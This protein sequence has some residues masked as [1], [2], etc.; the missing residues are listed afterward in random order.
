MGGVNYCTVSNCYF[1]GNSDYFTIIMAGPQVQAGQ[2]TLVAFQEN[3]LDTFNRFIN[4]VVYSSW[5]GDAVSFSLQSKSVFNNNIIRGGKVAIYMCRDSVV[6]HN[7]VYD[8]SSEGFF[9]SLPCI[10]VIVANNTIRS[11][12]A[13]GIKVSKQLEH[14]SYDFADY[15]LRILKNRLERCLLGFAINYLH[16]GYIFENSVVDS[17][18]SCFYLVDCQKVSIEKNEFAGFTT[19][20]NIFFSREVSLVNNKFYSIYPREANMFAILIDTNQSYLID[21]II[22]GNFT[23]FHLIRDIYDEDSEYGEH[24]ENV[25]NNNI[26]DPFYQHDEER[27]IMD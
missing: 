23:G 14:G 9:I 25:Y 2:D 5:S 4:N 11:V 18:H 12:E 16:D 6:T 13:S 22:G 10:D 1:Y 17:G 26:L 3:K 27:K 7:T 24:I 19:A 8:S 21:N 20:V 15:G